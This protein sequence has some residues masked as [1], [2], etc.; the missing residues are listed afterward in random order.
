MTDP[1]DGPRRDPWAPPDTAAE[2]PT[3]ALG[4][5][6]PM[7]LLHDS[8][9]IPIEGFQSDEPTSFWER[10]EQTFNQ[11]SDQVFS[12][13]LHPLTTAEWRLKLPSDS[14]SEILERGNRNARSAF[15]NSVEYSLRDASNLLPL[16]GDPGPVELIQ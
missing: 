4:A 10:F 15:V 12:D 1:D 6:Q 14:S 8:T 11:R 7:L 5:D 13:Q 2:Q 16:V 9:P 3:R